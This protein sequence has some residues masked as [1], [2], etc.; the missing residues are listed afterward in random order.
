MALSKFADFSVLFSISVTLQIK[1]L[2]EKSPRVL[3]LKYL[4]FAKEK[5]HLNQFY[6]LLLIYLEK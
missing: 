3:Q 2:Y 1:F 4:V 6:S 5:S